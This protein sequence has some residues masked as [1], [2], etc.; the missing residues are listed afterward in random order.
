MMEFFVDTFDVDAVRAVNDCFPIAGFTTNPN[1]LA[2]SG[3]PLYD[4]IEAYRDYVLETKQKIFVQVTAEDAA[5]MVSQAKRLR[6]FFGEQ[7]VVKL[8]AVREGYRACMQCS[9]LGI[10]VCVT[11]VHSTM[12]GLVAAEAGADYVAP[13]VTHIDNIGAHGVHCVEEM[14]RAFER[15]GRGCKVLGASFRTVEQ[16]E[17]LADV[18][19]DAVT[20]TP[21]TFDLLIAHPS[22]DLSLRGFKAAWREAFGDREITD[23]LPRL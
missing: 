21:E 20:I 15:A 5:E 1:I 4:L 19:C 17:S 23:F 2:R 11:V 3:R 6:A 9:R 10:S 13:Y 12:Q 16:I 18:G 8:P 14:V 22:T 7:L